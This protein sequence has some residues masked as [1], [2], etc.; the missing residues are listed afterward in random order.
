MGKNQADV[1]D[2]NPIINVVALCYDIYEIPRSCSVKKVS[3]VTLTLI[4]T[5]CQCGRVEMGKI[6]AN[7]ISLVKRYSVTTR[8]SASSS[9]LPTVFTTLIFAQA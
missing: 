5:V 2:A 7:P 8:T 3:G 9:P 4:F 6:D 1:A